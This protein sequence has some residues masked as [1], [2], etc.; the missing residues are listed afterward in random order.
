MELILMAVALLF[1]YFVGV[2]SGYRTKLREEDNSTTKFVEIEFKDDQV[3]A[4]DYPSGKFL[5]QWGQTSEDPA[6]YKNL[7]DSE[8][9]LVFFFNKTSGMFQE[10]DLRE[11]SNESV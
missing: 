6:R 1:G 11:A 8:T 4:Y 2:N 9:K 10:V 5:G 3:Y 7:Y